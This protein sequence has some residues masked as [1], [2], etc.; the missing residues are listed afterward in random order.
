M[1]DQ[2]FSVLVSAKHMVVDK[3]DKSYSVGS[4]LELHVQAVT[5]LLF[6]YLNAFFLGV[7]FEHQLLEE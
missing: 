4:V 5:T 6:F 2:L 1:R 3:V 7:V